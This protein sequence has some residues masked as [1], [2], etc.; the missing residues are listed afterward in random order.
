[1]PNLNEEEQAEALEMAF[2][3]CSDPKLLR[4]FGQHAD[5]SD[6][7]LNQLSV[8]IRELCN[9]VVPTVTVNQAH[10][11]YVIPCGRGFT[12]FG[13]QNLF[14]EANTM[15]RLLN[16]DP[17]PDA[18]FGTMAAYHRHT[19]I[20]ALFIASPHAYKTWFTP[21]TPEAVI[22]TLELARANGK[23]VRIFLGDSDTGCSWL[24][25]QD[26]VG[27][28]ARSRG[29]IPL[30][31]LVSAKGSGG[32]AIL[33]KNVIKIMDAVSGKVLYEHLKFHL[34]ELQLRDTETPELIAEGL[35][36]TVTANG[37]IHARFYTK[38]QAQDYIEFL[39][40]KRMR[41]PVAKKK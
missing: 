31:L 17:I 34:P 26:V 1:M 7:H 33:T 16:V 11:I 35:L 23:L 36:F 18:H 5:L 25:E 24:E 21:G 19:E 20:V 3:V 13:F 28:I 41:L 10:K 29:P 6:D 32:P 4:R 8:R 27:V 9:P 30:P 39:Q 2:F 37:G 14:N 15:A 38:R 40:G 12:C 22:Q